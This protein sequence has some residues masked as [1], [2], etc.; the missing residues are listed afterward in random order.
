MAENEKAKT[1]N[2]Q[3]KN[4]TKAKTTVKKTKTTVK[5]TSAG[6]KTTVKTTAKQKTTSKNAAS[7]SSIDVSKDV[8]K[9]LK[10]IPTA[11]K[12][13]GVLLFVLGLVTG[14]IIGKK[15]CENDTFELIECNT[16]YNVGSDNII[17]VSGVKIISFGKDVSDSV[18]LELSAGLTQN[19]DGTFT[20]EDTSKEGVYY[21]IYTTDNFKFKNIQ[22][23]RYIYVNDLEDTGESI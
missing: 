8:K 11:I 15:L 10:K 12:V 23:I 2:S 3:A 14:N 16:G 20:I 4:T 18:K 21:I 1:N 17:S 5:T 13:I 6:Q 7:S 19:D 9:I 22:K